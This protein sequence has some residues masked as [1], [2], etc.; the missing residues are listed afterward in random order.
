VVVSS[1]RARVPGGL[2]SRELAMVKLELR[3]S[4]QVGAD[5]DLAVRKAVEI[6]KRQQRVQSRGASICRPG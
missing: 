4:V 2:R 5:A 3:G 6:M 1:W